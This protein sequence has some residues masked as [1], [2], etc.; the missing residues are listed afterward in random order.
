M[1][2]FSYE[3]PISSVRIMKVLFVV[4]DSTA[5]GGTEILTFNIMHKLQEFGV[6]CFLISRHIYK[7]DKTCV[8]NMC[9]EDYVRFWSL[10]NNPLNKLSGSK[11]SNRFFKEVI[12]K[13]AT[14]LHVDWIVNHTYDLCPAIPTDGLWRTAQVFHWSVKG[15]ESN[16]KLNVQQKSF[17]FR[18]LSIVSLYNNIKQWHKAIP[19]FKRLVCLTAAAYEEIRTVSGLNSYDN[20]CYIPDA[21][22][23]THES[24]TISTLNNKT[25]VYV[26]R[27]SHEKGVMRLL[28]IWELVAKQMPDYSLHIYGDGNER[29]EMEEYIRKSRL[30]RVVF[31]GFSS[32]LESIYTRADLCLMTS[33]T[34][35]FG[36]VLIEAMYYGVP[37]IS[38][39]CPISPKEIIGDAGVTVSCFDEDAYANSVVELLKNKKLLNEYQYKSIERAKDFYID[40]VM[41]L[42]MKMFNSKD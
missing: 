27:L 13:T 21:L 29:G 31:K 28:R 4:S 36:M 19:H 6:E 12:R 11:K 17:A 30:E 38:F 35:G 9:K 14:K 16:L 23:Y 25:I 32:D 42:W 3:Y 7:G 8:L 20:I 41:G 2:S 26:G 10:Y 22:M 24:R 15:Y 40:K 39:D 1:Q 18:L 33:D 37:C 34:E 5:Y